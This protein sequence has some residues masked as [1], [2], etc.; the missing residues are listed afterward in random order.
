MCG[1]MNGSNSALYTLRQ[2]KENGSKM[3]LRRSPQENPFWFQVELFW[4][5]FYL[6]P[7]RVLPG[8]KM[9]LPGTTKVLHWVL[10]SGEQNNHFRFNGRPILGLSDEQYCMEDAL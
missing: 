1:E 2:I 3:V 9:V 6:E 10:L 8:T 7:I 5:G 4:L